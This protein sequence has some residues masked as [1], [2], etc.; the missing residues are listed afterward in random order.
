MSIGSQNLPKE[1]QI[2]AIDFGKSKVG[3]ALADSETKIAFGYAT[4]DNDKNLLDKITEIIQ[5]EGVKIVVMGKLKQWGNAENPEIKKL[6]EE[7]ES[8]INVQIEF[9]EEMFTTKMAQ[10]RIKETG[11]KDIKELDNQ[12]A[13]KIILEDFLIKYQAP[14]TEFQTT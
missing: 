13:A 4:L 10:E 14:N 1:S 5:K 12:E 6:A 7:I 2:L 8:R 9:Q 3:L 11:R